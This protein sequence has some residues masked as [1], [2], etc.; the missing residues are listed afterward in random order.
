MYQEWVPLAAL[1]LDAAIGD[2]R[3]KYHP[4]VVIG[5]LI[6][7][8]EK[9]LYNK[10]ASSVMQKLSG[11][12]LVVITLSI[13]YIASWSIL[14]LAEMYDSRLSFLLG[15]IL[16]SF[17]ISPRSLKESAFEIMNYLEQNDLANARFKVGWIVGR[18]TKN[19]ESKDISRAT[20]E[21][22][23]ENIVDG[24]IS[25]LFY[26]AI[27][28]VPLACMY[29]AVNTL[30]SMIA[31]KNDKYINFGM[32]A[33]R[34]DDVFNFIPARIN[35]VLIII[36]A[37]LLGYS[38]SNALRM[39]WRDA[40]KHPSPN[41]GFSEA[42]VA[43]ALGIRLGGLNYYFGV[44]HFRAYMGDDLTTI[45]P[46]HIRDTV[47]IMYLAAVMFTVIITILKL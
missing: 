39:I 21:T 16:V 18:D 34:V 30:D 15:V 22:V 33:A 27:G 29:R 45:E 6:S 31:Y 32:I 8:L 13:V 14:Q 9:L 7:N 23:A 35:A 37:F 11:G 46:R 19:L 38:H 20:I 41:S 28:G 24:V 26:L 1:V 12:L 2:P 36:A 43:G 44:P 4:V 42:G 25:P 3:V 5:N 40:A 10:A 17:T 47:K